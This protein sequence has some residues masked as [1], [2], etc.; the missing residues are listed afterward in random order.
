VD[1]AAG[2]IKQRG[3]AD[4]DPPSY[5]RE[6]E[7]LVLA[8]VLLVQQAPDQALALLQRWGALAVAQ[9]RTD[10]S[11][12]LGALQALAHAACGDRDVA[13]AVLAQTLGLAAP[14]EYLRVFVDE[15]PPMAGLVRELLAGRHDQRLAAADI[16]RDYLARLAQTFERAACP[17]AHLPVAVAWW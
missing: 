6:R 16:L 10:S 15:G 2:W 17:S 7:Y 5:P 1:T 11:I 8:R 3:L 9:G 13:L 4:Q 12:K 14:E